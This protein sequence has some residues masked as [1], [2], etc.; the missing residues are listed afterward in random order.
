MSREVQSPA[1]SRWDTR[2]AL[3]WLFGKAFAPEVPEADRT[4]V[5]AVSVSMILLAG[6]K[7]PH[8]D[9]PVSISMADD[10]VTCSPTFKAENRASPGL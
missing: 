10:L 5:L 6:L 3:R 7:L 1:A 8:D 4:P 9:V 2:R